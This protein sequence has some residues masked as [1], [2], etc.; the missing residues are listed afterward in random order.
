MA[1]HNNEKV[2]FGVTINTNVEETNHLAPNIFDTPKTPNSTAAPVPRS[3]LTTPMAPFY[4]HPSVEHSQQSL[5]STK[6]PLAVYETDLEAA[7]TTTL[8]SS[9]NLDL[10]LAYSLASNVPS[11]HRSSCEGRSK[12]CTMWPTKQTLRENARVEKAKQRQSRFCS[13]GHVTGA[14][15]TLN[16]KQ[17]LWFKI[18][19]ALFIVA[20]AVALG[21]G[22]TRAV[23]GGVWAS[24]G[25]QKTI[26]NHS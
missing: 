19:I 15:G 12:E 11:G 16:K 2:T 17:K 4:N 18:A 25:Q 7:R 26:P 5:K 24:Q 14:W 21:V 10:P 1:A 22:I 23:G 3:N 8:A 6:N 9:S 13:C 20:L